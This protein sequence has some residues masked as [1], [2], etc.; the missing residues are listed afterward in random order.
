M[1]QSVKCPTLGF[2]SGH[3]LRVMGSSTTLGSALSIEPDWDTLSL[4]LSLSLSLSLFLSLSLCPSPARACTL[5]LSLAFPL[6]IKNLK[7]SSYH[8]LRFW[9]NTAVLV[10]VVSLSVF[11]S[12]FSNNESPASVI[13]SIFPFP[14]QFPGHVGA[15][16]ALTSSP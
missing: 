6:K 12:P 14:P 16:W 7:P 8:H 10:L 4:T 5:T 3:D 11:V 2:R 15:S 9:S 13:L 1:A